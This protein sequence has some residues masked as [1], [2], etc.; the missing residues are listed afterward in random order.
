MKGCRVIDTEPKPQRANEPG[1]YVC[2]RCGER[3]SGPTEQYVCPGPLPE[4]REPL[5]RVA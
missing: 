2:D 4:K 1:D 5:R 3:L